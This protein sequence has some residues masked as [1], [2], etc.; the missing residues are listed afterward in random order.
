MVYRLYQIQMIYL[1]TKILVQRFGIGR[2]N[3]PLATCL[4]APSSTRL[5]PLVGFKF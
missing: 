3:I 1:P 4:V 5:W 2:D